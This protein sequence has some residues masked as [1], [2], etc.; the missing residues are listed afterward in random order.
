VNVYSR[1]GKGRLRNLEPLNPDY[2][3]RYGAKK[4]GRSASAVNKVIKKIGSSQK[5]VERRLRR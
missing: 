1:A 2:E 3:V 5:R 4:T